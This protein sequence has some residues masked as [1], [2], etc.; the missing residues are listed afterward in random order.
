[1][2]KVILIIGIALLLVF[3]VVATINRTSFDQWSTAVMARCFSFRAPEKA[4]KVQ[5]SKDAE[6]IRGLI[7]WRSAA[8]AACSTMKR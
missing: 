3:I 4:I 1:M 8:Y 7:L 5:T 2:K 6:A